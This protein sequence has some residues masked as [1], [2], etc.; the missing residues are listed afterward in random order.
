MPG[1]QRR[2]G[3]PSSAPAILPIPRYFVE[4]KAKL[5]PLGNG[6]FELKNGE[7][8]VKFILTAEVSNMYSQDGKGRRIHTLIFAPSFEVVEAIH[9]KLG[10]LGKLSSDGRPIFTFCGKGSG[11]DDLEYLRG[12]HADP[13]PRVDPLVF[14][15]R[16]EFRIRFD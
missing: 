5:A 13:G 15:L 8:G 10:T 11:E 14:H 7:K 2:R 1:G 6:L 3:L 16:G 12:V 4:L 9:S